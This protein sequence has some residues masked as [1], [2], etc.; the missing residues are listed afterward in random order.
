MAE[1]V[2]CAADA[3]EWE[4]TDNYG[5]VN[6]VVIWIV[7][8]VAKCCKLEFFPMYVIFLIQC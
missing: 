4:I 3:K 1:G 2:F 8:L 6:F 7:S 5:G